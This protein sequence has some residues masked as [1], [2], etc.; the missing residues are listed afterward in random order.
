MM[1]ICPIMVRNWRNLKHSGDAHIFEEEE[2]I[3]Y[4]E[5]LDLSIAELELPVRTNNCLR[6]ANI[7]YIGELVQQHRKNITNIKNFGRKSLKDVN[8][9][10]SIRGLSLGMILSDWTCPDKR[11]LQKFPKKHLFE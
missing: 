10:L 3:I 2:L 8:E 4:K 7:D 1:E 9:V 11:L 6:S 5:L